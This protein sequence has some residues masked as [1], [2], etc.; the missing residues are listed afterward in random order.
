MG[1]AMFSMEYKRTERKVSVC[2][3]CGDRIKYG[4]ADKKF[5]CD[6]CRSRHFNSQK[7]SGRAF[8][9]R[10]MRQISR[11]YEI[12]DNLY[13]SG[14]ASIDITD[15]IVQ[16]FVPSVMTSRRK[17]RGRDECA[18][19]DIKYILTDTR[20]SSIAKIQNFD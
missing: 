17:S 12:L 5:C 13:K 10:I 15:L 6:E 4:R 1:K 8:R 2:L 14:V 7:K 18:C 11:N 9:R 20:V 3:E 16:G 19:F